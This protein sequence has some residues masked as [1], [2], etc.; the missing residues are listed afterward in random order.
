VRRHRRTHDENVVDERHARHLLEQES[1]RLHEVLRL[2]EHEHLDE[3]PEEES[4]G[5]LS[6]YDQHQ[7]DVASDVF[8]RE[9]EFSLLAR[10]KL[11]L[12]DVEDA[13]ARLDRDEYGRCQSCGAL[14]PEERL[15]A[16]P[17]TRFC[18]DHQSFWE[19]VR[20]TITPPPGPMPGDKT[21]SIAE[22]M[23]LAALLNLDLLSTD[24]EVSE[25]LSLGPEESAMHLS[26]PGADERR[27]GAEQIEDIESRHSDEEDRE[28]E[29]G[30]E[31]DLEWRHEVDAATDGEE[32]L[33]SV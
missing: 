8:E 11:D 9:K 28:R 33:G 4:F 2:L 10:V 12:I 21:T 30:E 13:F 31:A 24:D 19:A 1:K 14:I 29:A 7:A 5:E 32:R 23:E 25:P 6:T 22:L 27:P 15:E 17:A 16:M 26:G 20:M 18:I 3:S